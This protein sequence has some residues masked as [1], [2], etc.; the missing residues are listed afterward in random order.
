MR[1]QR[2][3]ENLRPARGGLGAGDRRV[4]SERR[5]PTAAGATA[6]G[7]ERE[8]ESAYRV[9]ASEGWLVREERC[10]FCKRE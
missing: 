4:A 10:P 3:G 9:R 2:A 6:A 7:E 5:A 8:W 1:K